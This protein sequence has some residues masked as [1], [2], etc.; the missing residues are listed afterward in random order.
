MRTFFRKKVA[1]DRLWLTP[2]KISQWAFQQCADGNDNKEMWEMIT[3]PYWAYLYCK[4]IALRAE[5]AINVKSP[6]WS[7]LLCLKLENLP[8][9]LK[10]SEKWKAIYRDLLP[11][12]RWSPLYMTSD[13]SSG[14]YGS[15]SISV[16]DN[17]SST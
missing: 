15:R 9:L 14:K 6:K 1:E 12:A 4:T 2:K 5:V 16:Y 17:G 8:N 10:Y 13:S 11:Y 7:G 3:D